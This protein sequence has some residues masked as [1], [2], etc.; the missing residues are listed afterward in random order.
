MKIFLFGF[1]CLV[2]CLLLASCVVE[3]SLG[4]ESYVK[5]STFKTD[6]DCTLTDIKTNIEDTLYEDVTNRIEELRNRES[7]AAMVV[8]ENQMKSVMEP[9]VPSGV[10]ICNQLLDVSNKGLL[11]MT[12][13]EVYAVTNLSEADMAAL[14]YTMKTIEQAM[15]EYSNNDNSAQVVK[16]L[17]RDDYIDCIGYALLGCSGISS[18]CAYIEQTVKLASVTTAKQIATALF[19]RTLGW[20]GAAYAA[21]EFS[22]CLKSKKKGK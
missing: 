12:E 19:K 1:N 9:L 6:Y 7:R 13:E 8:T 22:D 2:A 15:D 20:V 4:N 11:E 16:E 17:T 21:Y 3:D 5:D 14:A 18:G 10:Q